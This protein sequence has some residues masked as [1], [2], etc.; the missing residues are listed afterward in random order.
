M[1]P[2]PPRQGSNSSFTGAGVIPGLGFC[3]NKFLHSHMLPK[4][5]QAP[6]R[7][8]A[9]SLARAGSAGGEPHSPVPQGCLA[10]GSCSR[11][12]QGWDTGRSCWDTKS[13]AV[14]DVSR[15]RAQRKEERIQWGKSSFTLPASQALL[16]CLRTCQSLLPE[17]YL[18]SHLSV[19]GAR[20]KGFQPASSCA[21][22]WAWQVQVVKGS[23][24]FTLCSAAQ[25]GKQLLHF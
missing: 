13:S 2:R 18:R 14:P 8:G 23:V 9:G 19:A 22:G 15:N 10:V 6:H 24:W 5:W 1:A 16:P 20:I 12:S 4:P 25:N 21:L 7:H 17:K 11:L 3:F